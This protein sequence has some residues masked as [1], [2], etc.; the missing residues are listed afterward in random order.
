VGGFV[1]SLSNDA[2]S[3][4]IRALRTQGRADILSR[5]QVMAVDNQAATVAVGQSVPFLGGTVLGVGQSQQ[6]VIYRD[7]GVILNVVPKIFPDGKVTM[8]VTPQVSSVAPGTVNLGNGVNSPIFNQQIVDTTV[9]AR[10]GETVVIGG[11]ITRNVSKTENKI[12]WLGDLPYLGAAFRY[13]QEVKTKQELVVILTPRVVRNQFERQRI[14]AEEGRRV[15]WI[16]GDVVKTQGATGMDPLFRPAMPGG[17]S[18]SVTDGAMP[19]LPLPTPVPAPS[20]PLAPVLPPPGTLLPS[21]GGVAPIPAPAPPGAQLPSGPAAPARI[22]AP[23]S[24]PV[25]PASLGALSGSLPGAQASGGV[26]TASFPSNDR[27]LAGLTIPRDMVSGGTTPTMVASVP[28]LST[29]PTVPAANPAVPAAAA[30]MSTPAP[31]AGT[32]TPT[33]NPVPAT[34][35][36]ESDRWRLF[37]RWR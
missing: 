5:P 36:K 25:P 37:P 18:P 21:S 12:P 28:P 11:L 29:V 34:K 3:L 14:L 22:P 32:A 17:P 24:T 15:D 10:D 8:R 13:R 23:G 26:T 9:T 30:T 33:A 16:L 7:V 4:L 6:N 1:F 35:G 27:P 31:S 20:G 19:T 2:F